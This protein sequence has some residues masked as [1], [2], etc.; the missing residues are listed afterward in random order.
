[1]QES[2]V[3]M[4]LF[5]NLTHSVAEDCLTASDTVQVPIL[6]FNCSLCGR[7]LDKWVRRYFGMSSFHIRCLKPQSFCIASLQVFHWDG[8]NSE[9][10]PLDRDTQAQPPDADQVMT[11]A[12]YS[13]HSWTPHAEK[14]RNSSLPTNVTIVKADVT[15]RKNSVWFRQGTTAAVLR[16]DDKNMVQM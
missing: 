14:R 2:D 6:S 16:E 9:T 7:T 15:L 4:W 1:M 3:I 13:L 11:T 8:S 12:V 10:H 5:Y